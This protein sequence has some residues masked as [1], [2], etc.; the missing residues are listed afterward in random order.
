MATIICSGMGSGSGFSRRLPGVG[1]VVLEHPARLA[2]E[3]PGPHGVAARG[4]QVGLHLGRRDVRLLDGE[5]QRAGPHAGRA[6]DHGRGH[7]AAASRR[8]RRPAPAVGATASMTSGH[9]TMLPTSPVWPPPSVPWQTTKS[10]PAVLVVQRVLDRAGQGGD[11]QAVLVD[12]GDHVVRRRA[13]GVGDQLHLVV[14]QDDLD[15]GRRRWPR[16][17][18]AARAAGRPGSSGTPWSA[19]I[20]WAKS[21]WSSGTMA[22]S[23]ASSFYRVELAH[24]LVLAGDDDVDAVGV[25]AHVLVEPD[26]LDLE[27]LGAEADGARARRSPPALDTAATTSRQWVKAKMGNSMPRRSQSSLCTGETSSVGPV[28]RPPA[29]LLSPADGA[30]GKQNRF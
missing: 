15:Q 3:R 19:R 21:R 5:P 12:L 6:H 25:V 27:L 13:E 7:L 24:A 18:P 8:R 29:E 22:C 30:A 1:P 4:G 23:S 10:T 14:L 11:Q 17:S 2:G 26:Q 28:G 20:F 16:S 9:S